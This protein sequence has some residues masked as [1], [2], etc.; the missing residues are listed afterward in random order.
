MEIKPT[1][2]WKELGSKGPGSVPGKHEK[3]LSPALLE[4]LQRKWGSQA[5]TLSCQSGSA[6]ERWRVYAKLLPLTA[7]TSE[8]VAKR[9]NLEAGPRGRLRAA[10]GQQNQ[11][12]ISGC[13][14]GES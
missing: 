10:V 11:R 5:G 13:W 7:T 14:V 2:K 8:I 1:Q 3:N 9:G 12:R 4:H 6:K